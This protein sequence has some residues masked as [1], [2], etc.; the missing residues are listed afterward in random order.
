MFSFLCLVLFFSCSVS[1]YFISSSSSFGT[2]LLG[3]LYYSNSLMEI[4]YGY[5]WYTTFFLTMLAL[6]GLLS[7]NFSIHYMG[8]SSLSANYLFFNILVFLIT[9]VILTCSN[10]LLTSLVLWE[11]LGLVSFFLILFYNNCVSLQASVITLV[12]SRLGDIFLFLIAGYSIFNSFNNNSVSYYFLVLSLFFIIGSKSAFYPMISWLLEAM[13]APTPVSALVHS[14]TLVAAGVWFLSYYLNVF[15]SNFLFIIIY[16]SCISTICITSYCSCVITDAKKIVALSTSNNISWCLLY[17]ISG[18][19]ILSLLQ[20]LTHGVGKCLFFTLMGDLMSSNE[21]G[22]NYKS[23]GNNNYS[24]FSINLFLSIFCLAGVPY[25]G[26][27]FSKHFFFGNGLGDSFSIINYFL[28][29]G[30]LLGTNVYSGRLY[31]ILLN[32]SNGSNVRYNNVFLINTFFL[33]LMLL[34]NYALCFNLSEKLNGSQNLSTQIIFIVF[35]GLIGGYK[36]GTSNNI[37]TKGSGASLYFLDV[38]VSLLGNSANYINKLGVLSV[39]RWDSFVFNNMYLF[40]S[41]RLIFSVLVGFSLVV[42][43]FL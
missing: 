21:G 20:L 19:F 31:S 6:C 8:N 5:G 40:L 15:C 38:L 41:S 24:W 34:F 37:Q 23:F 33:L 12:T 29:L 10:N 18:D 3:C 14:S 1:S 42:L 27:Y 2:E 30:G 26:I 4:Y 11:Y 22:Q 32:N 35:F 13:R 17:I 43:L 9:M 39:Y 16:L 36:L 7:L 28:L 25:V